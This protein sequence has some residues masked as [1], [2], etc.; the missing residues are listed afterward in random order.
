MIEERKLKLSEQLE[1][2]HDSKAKG[3]EEDSDYDPDEF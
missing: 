2:V 3:Q 1:T